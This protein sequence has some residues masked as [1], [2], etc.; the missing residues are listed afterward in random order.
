MLDR[1]I[2]KGGQKLRLGYTTG[3]CAAGA[4][5]AAAQKLIGGTFPDRVFLMTP[6][7][8]GLELDILDKSSGDDFACCAVEKDGGDDPDITSGI[9]VYARAEKIPE[10]VEIVGGEGI[11]IVTKAGLDRP[12][13]DYAI[14]TVPRKMITAAVMEMAE[15]YEYKGGF[16]IKI[17]IPAG[18]ELAKK[19]YNPRMGIEGGISV[20]GTSGIVEPM[21]T[22]ALIDTIRAEASMRRAEGIKNL[23]VTPGNYGESFLSEHIH[24]AAE[25]SVKCSNFIGEALNIAIELE[26]ESVLI[27]GHIGKLV[28]LGAGIMNTHSAEADGR[29]EVLVTCGL[30]A[31]CSRETLVEITKCA[32][33]DGALELLKNEEKLSE[34][35]DILC[36]RIQYYLD[37]KVKGRIKAGA[38][39]FSNAYGQLGVTEEGRRFLTQISEEYGNG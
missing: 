3:S 32:V 10:S 14:N 30:L 7:G 23:I 18:T 38:V 24:N 27:V 22:A 4:A 26:F 31:G 1:Y 39:I 11:G 35:M 13:G 2:S 21:S 6:K 25:K 34:T 20:I 28:K 33:T 37:A 5:K 29:I 17:F 36:R 8:I 15:L 16:R 9:Y 19:T 12:V